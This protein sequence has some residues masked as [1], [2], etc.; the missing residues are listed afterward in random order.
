MRSSISSYIWLTLR[1]RG[2]SSGFSFA[3]AAA[4]QAWWA[5]DFKC[6]S[7]EYCLKDVQPAAVAKALAGDNVDNDWRLCGLLLR[8]TVILNTS[9]SLLSLRLQIFAIIMITSSLA[10][11]P[12]GKK[13]RHRGKDRPCNIKVVLQRHLYGLLSM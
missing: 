1:A 7:I 4:A 13:V 6:A 5:A 9:T 10:S 3:A 8:V 11:E 2:V 12:K